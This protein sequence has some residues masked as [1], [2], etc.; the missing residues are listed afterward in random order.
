MGLFKRKNKKN[1]KAG[2]ESDTFEIRKAYYEADWDKC[3]QFVEEQCKLM[4][5]ASYQLEDAKKRLKEIR[6]MKPMVIP[7]P[8]EEED[9][10]E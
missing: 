3:R 8:D 6:S 9:E 7:K 4:K 10:E 2:N 5:D 1:I